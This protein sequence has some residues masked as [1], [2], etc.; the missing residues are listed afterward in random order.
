MNNDFEVYLF[1]RNLMRS[2][3]FFNGKFLEIIFWFCKDKVSVIL[4]RCFGFS[5]AYKRVVYF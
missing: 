2:K 1:R 5:F 3:C 4:R